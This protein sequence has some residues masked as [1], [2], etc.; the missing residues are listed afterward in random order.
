MRSPI[1]IIVRAAILVLLLAPWVGAAAQGRALRLAVMAPEQKEAARTF[2]V[3]LA[4]S[5]ESSATVLDQDMVASAYSA[6][7]VA[8]PFNM[9]TAESRN[10][11][12]A[13]GCDFLVLVRAADQR[14]S[15]SERE[16]YYESYAVIFAVST[17]TGRLVD[18]IHPRFES[19]RS[20]EAHQMLVASIPKFA[21]SL[22]LRLREV[23]QR[24]RTEQK[25]PYVEEVPALGSPLAANFRAPVP[26]RR[27]K[28]EYTPTAFLY[29]VAATVELEMD[30]DAAG[31]ITRAE[32][33][34]WAG[35]GLDQSVESAVRSM[36]WRA[37]ERGGRSLPMRVLLRYNFKRPDK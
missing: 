16:E 28:P 24:E 31:N 19:R 13:I 17:R 35:Y 4:G 2:A 6:S 26:Y 10:V 12:A 33:V 15:S 36:N 7:N 18:W 34:R 25:T 21:A 27:L 14:R 30:L 29:E 22:V 5:L 1:F 3:N 32:I 23:E 37:A 20:S 9:T 8:T 11:G